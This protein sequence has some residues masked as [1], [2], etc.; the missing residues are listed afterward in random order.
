M[1]VHDELVYEVARQD[2]TTVAAVIR[3][4]MESCVKF[5]VRFPVKVKVGGS[6]GQMEEYVAPKM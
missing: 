6:F 3:E 1:Q 4:E 5:S 2:L